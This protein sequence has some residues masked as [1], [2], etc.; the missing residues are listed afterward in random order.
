MISDG[1][2]IIAT[3][4]VAICTCGDRGCANAGRQMQAAI[5]SESLA[6]VVAALGALPTLGP[7]DQRERVWQGDLLQGLAI[8]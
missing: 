4:A 2:V 5:P 7:D 3:A 6:D 8:R 1:N